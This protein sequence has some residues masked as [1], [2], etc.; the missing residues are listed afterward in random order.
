[1]RAL[2]AFDLA[3]GAPGSRPATPILA[4]LVDEGNPGTVLSLASAWAW[5]WVSGRSLP[6]RFGGLGLSAPAADDH[7]VS[8]LLPSAAAGA[9]VP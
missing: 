4:G 2:L 8:L 3:R 7:A 5:A 9:S 6:S 1:L